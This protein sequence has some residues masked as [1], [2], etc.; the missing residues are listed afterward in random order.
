MVHFQN[1]EDKE[2]ILRVSRKIKNKRSR[3]RVKDHNSTGF[4]NSHTGSLEDSET[5]P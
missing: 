5:M 2:E 4:L 1:I 3:Q